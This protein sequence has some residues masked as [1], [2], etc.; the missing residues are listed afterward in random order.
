ML[1]KTHL[2]IGAA[3]AL[4]FLPFMNNKLMFLP[5]VLISS[6]LPDVDTG[7]SY[8]GHR[9][10]FRPIQWLFSHRGFIHSYTFCIGLAFVF[11]LF[12]PVMAF[13]FFLGYSFHLAADSFTEQGIRPFWPLDATIKGFVTTGGRTEYMTFVTFVLFDIV[14]FV[15]LFI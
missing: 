2:A 11:A 5:V 7:S 9:G 14:L 13:P 10:I 12:Y 4:Y 3:A 8:L 1:W 6:L 15:V